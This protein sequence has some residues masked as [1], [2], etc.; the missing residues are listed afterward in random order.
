VIVVYRRD[1]PQKQRF[2]LAGWATQ[3]N[4]VLATPA[5]SPMT[6]AITAQTARLA[7][8]CQQLNIAELDAFHTRWFTGG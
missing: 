6:A 1:L 7:F 4:G 5:D 3:S 8:T 2:A